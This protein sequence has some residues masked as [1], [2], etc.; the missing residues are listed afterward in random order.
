[1]NGLLC[2]AIL[3]QGVL[4]VCSL[5]S[6]NSQ[7]IKSQKKPDVS[8]WPVEAR[9]QIAKL[10]EQI[11][12]QDEAISVLI[13]NLTVAQTENQLFQKQLQ[14]YR[15]QKEIIGSS[16]TDLQL[17]ERLVDSV[18]NLY[19][20]EKEKVRLIQRVTDLNQALKVLLKTAEFSDLQA[21]S[22][23][24]VELR[25]T[26]RLLEEL[27]GSGVKAGVVDLNN[28]TVMNLNE[29]L[30]LVILNVGRA[31]GVQLNMPFVIL[32]DDKVVGNVR[33]VEVRDKFSGAVIER[34]KAGE[35][36]REGDRAI[37]EVSRTF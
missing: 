24:E 11:A 34:Y 28:A 9:E 12:R 22:A 19:A 26:N 8:Q 18:R 5:D 16:L 2:G 32:R 23:L 25:L 36:I 20:S 37:V 4:P 1:M 3:L 15:L 29:N 6:N 21:R 30:S 33:I 7:R 10:N 31:Q 35:E 14:E 13:E 17:Q 27:K